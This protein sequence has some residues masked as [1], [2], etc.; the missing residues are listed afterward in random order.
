MKIIIDP[1]HGGKDTGGGS[2]EFWLE[3]DMNLK[4]SLYQ[5]QGFW[6]SIDTVKDVNV[7]NELWHSKL[8]SWV[9]W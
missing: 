1:G 4:I 6:H 2:N 3:K 8:R 7:M 9:K 5:H